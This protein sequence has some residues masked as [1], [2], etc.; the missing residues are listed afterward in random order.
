MTL[1]STG[2]VDWLSRT[3]ATSA[4]SQSIPE[5]FIMWEVKQ[6]ASTRA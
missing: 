5:M 2:D 6:N 3:Q 1:P 4:L